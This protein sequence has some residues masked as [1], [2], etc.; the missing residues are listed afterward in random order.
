MGIEQ[1]LTVKDID[2]ALILINAYKSGYYGS[3]TSYN[4][5]YYG[6]KTY[7]NFGLCWILSEI[8]PSLTDEKIDRIINLLLEIDGIAPDPELG[9]E[10][11]FV[12][13]WGDNQSVH[14]I[15]WYK[16]R[17]GALLKARDILVRENYEYYV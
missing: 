14:P 6:S 11:G 3:T 17:I 1:Y 15:I 2:R 10:D 16:K 9:W 12:K 4:S 7:C 8:K 13:E 5:V